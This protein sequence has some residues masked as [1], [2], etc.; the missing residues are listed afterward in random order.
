MTTCSGR[1]LV[2]DHEKLFSTMVREVLEPYGFQ[3]DTAV[4]LPEIVDRITP[5]LPDLIFLDM[6]VPGLDGLSLLERLRGE[7]EAEG[8]RVLIT[9]PCLG[10]GDRHEALQAGAS[11][12]LEKPVTIHQLQR[13]VAEQFGGYC[14]P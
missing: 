11:G 6:L 9:N 7:S 2:I 14:F 4:D 13:A 3:V 10:Q 1:V 5:L 8:L 12:F